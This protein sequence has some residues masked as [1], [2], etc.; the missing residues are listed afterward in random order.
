LAAREQRLTV[1]AEFDDFDLIAAFSFAIEF[2]SA[3]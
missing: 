2:G 1:I 3:E